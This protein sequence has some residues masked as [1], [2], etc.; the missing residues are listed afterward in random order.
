MPTKIAPA[1]V[2]GNDVMPP[3]SAAVSAS[4][5]VS[6]PTCTS[7]VE[8]PWVAYSTS[9]IP[10]SRPPIVQIAVDIILG[11]MPVRRARSGLVADARTASPKI[12]CPSSHHSPIVTTGT[13]IERHELRAR[14][15]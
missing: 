4:N 2:R 5:S 1:T 13:M 12:V 8:P 3:I 15:R 7:S 9:A 11:L 10:E 14:S 6:G